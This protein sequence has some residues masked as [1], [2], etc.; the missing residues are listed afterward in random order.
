MNVATQ[1]VADIIIFF[2]NLV[3]ATFY[4]F[5]NVIETVTNGLWNAVMLIIKLAL[6]VTVGVVQDQ[7]NAVV[8]LWKLGWGAVS[9][10]VTD[11]WTTIGNTVKTG[12]NFVIEAINMFI[13]AL[14]SLHINIPAIKV[15]GTNFGTPAIDLGFNIPD[16]PMLAAGGVVYNP[17]LAMIGEQG[18]EAVLPLSSLGG[19]AGGVGGQQQIVI[20][21]QGGIFPADG[22][23][24][25][26]IGDLLAKSILRGLRPTVNYAP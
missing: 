12:V 10:I 23:T 15:P 18:P 26:Q 25:K 1:G 8:E 7:L 2:I 24:M 6:D 14:D 17:V 22:S 13:N 19:G 5:S 20:N 9:T 16:I 11:V 21:I 3:E 4:V